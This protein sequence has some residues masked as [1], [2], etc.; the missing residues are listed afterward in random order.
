[1]T[2]HYRIYMT[3][4]VFDNRDAMVGTRTYLHTEATYLTTGLPLYLA[5]LLNQECIDCGDYDRQFFVASISNTGHLVKVL[6]P[7]PATPHEDIDF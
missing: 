5:G 6:P 7:A 2:T 3:V 4:P 1:M